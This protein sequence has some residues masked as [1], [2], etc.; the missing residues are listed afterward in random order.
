MATATVSVSAGPVTVN[1]TFDDGLTILY[2]LK[3]TGT[4]PDTKSVSHKVFTNTPG[5]PG[6]FDRSITATASGPNLV[7]SNTVTYRVTCT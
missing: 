3:F 6:T 4:G 1:V 7:Q 5:D 2:T